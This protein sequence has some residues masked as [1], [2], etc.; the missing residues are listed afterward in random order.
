MTLIG[1]TLLA[2]FT[3]AGWLFGFGGWADWMPQYFIVLLVGFLIVFRSIPSKGFDTRLKLSTW[4]AAGGGFIGCLAY[5]AALVTDGMFWSELTGNPALPTQI[6]LFS[7]IP[8][9]VSAA[10]VGQIHRTKTA[11]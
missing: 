11:A 9:A 6:L 2:T 5:M 4:C 7:T 3:T 10:L 1:S 8:A